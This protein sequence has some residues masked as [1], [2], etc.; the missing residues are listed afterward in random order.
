MMKVKG[1]YVETYGGGQYTS[2][3][4]YA[5]KAQAESHAKSIVYW[6]GSPPRV[7]TDYAPPKW[8]MN[9]PVAAM[10]AFKDGK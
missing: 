7:T 2:I 4:Y 5:N 10:A 1:Y 9:C 8:G 3:A 6:H